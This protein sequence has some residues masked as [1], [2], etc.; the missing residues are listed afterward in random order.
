MCFTTE[1]LK[2]TFQFTETLA[3]SFLVLTFGLFLLFF[4]LSDYRPHAQYFFCFSAAQG[5]YTTRLLDKASVQASRSSPGKA[6]I[7]AG[8]DIATPCRYFEYFAMYFSNTVRNVSRLSL[9][10]PGIYKSKLDK[11]RM[12]ALCPVVRP[13]KKSLCTTDCRLST[14]GKTRGDLDFSTPNP[15]FFY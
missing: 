11:L 7:A 8:A 15:A 10:N 5:E 13:F 4:F 12:R 9:K 3:L 6:L 1:I 14:L 2:L